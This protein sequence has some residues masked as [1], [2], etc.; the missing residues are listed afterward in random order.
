MKEFFSE[1]RE[2]IT[3]CVNENPGAALWRRNVRKYIPHV[4]DIYW[5]GCLLGNGSTA[6]ISGGQTWPANYYKVG[7]PGSIL[8]SHDPGHLVYVWS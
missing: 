8:V 6:L 2:K 7:W 5:S 3:I 4:N 1:K